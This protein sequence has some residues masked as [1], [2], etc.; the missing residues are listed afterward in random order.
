MYKSESSGTEKVKCHTENQIHQ[1]EEKKE[2]EE[3]RKDMNDV[4]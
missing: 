2:E 1:H 3:E 4:T